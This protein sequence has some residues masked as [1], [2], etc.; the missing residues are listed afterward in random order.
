MAKKQQQN[1]V[2]IVPLNM[3]RLRG[4]MLRVPPK[5]RK[6]REILVVYG[7]LTH[8]EQLIPLAKELN[9]YGG[10]TVPDLPGF[11]GMRSFYK[12]G[13]KP[14]IDNL[15]DY[16]AAFI[17]LFYKRRHLSVIGLDFGFS[18]IT[19][20]LQKYPDL[21]KKV[22]LLVSLDGFTHHEDFYI[23]PGQKAVNKWSSAI[24]SFRIPAGLAR[25][26]FFRPVFVKA[27][28]SLS[29]EVDLNNKNLTTKL[30]DQQIADNVKN[31]QLTDIRTYMS[32]TKAKYKLNVCQATVEL[33][34]THV[35]YSGKRFN[36]DRLEQHLKVIFI[37]VELIEQPKLKP[38]KTGQAK[39][40]YLP[41][42]PELRRV[43][44]Q[45]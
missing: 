39:G 38:T 26:T 30:I 17:K 19:R 5:G 14:T 2:R 8:L 43:L 12:I 40:L 45:Q 16:L 35:T 36:Q 18:V 4:R 29:H 9:K 13:E 1:V 41:L 22:E 34:L 23:T 21:A 28:H 25:Y 37:S 11:G 10:V 3:N 42:S 15:A 44:R 27:W 24:L 7:Q 32:T 6:K 31:W 20:M 33:P